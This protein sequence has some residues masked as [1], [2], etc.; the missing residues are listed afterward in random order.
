MKNKPSNDL[1]K[2]VIKQNLLIWV[3]AKS[4]IDIDDRL[5]KLP[6][7]PPKKPY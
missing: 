1:T 4:F 7:T 6:N 3:I 2:L 5:K